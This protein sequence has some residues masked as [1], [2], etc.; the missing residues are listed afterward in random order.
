MESL[1]TN[2]NL[3]KLH[4]YTSKLINQATSPCRFYL[5]YEYLDQDLEK[6]CSM[7]QKANQDNKETMLWK[8]FLNLSAGL[9]G[10]LS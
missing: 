7:H 4:A 6:D 3:I 2:Q 9:I 5:F 8:V 1:S 10:L